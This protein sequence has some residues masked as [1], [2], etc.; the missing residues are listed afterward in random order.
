M[1]TNKRLELIYNAKGPLTLRIER[2]THDQTIA[3]ENYQVTHVSS[4]KRKATVTDMSPIE[5]QPHCRTYETEIMENI[6]QISSMTVRSPA[7]TPRTHTHQN[8]KIRRLCKIW[9]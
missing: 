3:I 9:W 5:N 1:F 7:P 8:D 4:D 6:C 2:I